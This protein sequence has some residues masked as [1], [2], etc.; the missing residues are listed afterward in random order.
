M[1]SSRRQ[2]KLSLCRFSWMCQTNMAM[3]RNGATAPVLRQNEVSWAPPAIIFYEYSQAA[4]T[5]TQRNRQ[6]WA[7]RHNSFCLIN[8]LSLPTLLC[9]FNLKS[10]SPATL[11]CW[12][13]EGIP[14]IPVQGIPGVI[15]K[16]NLCISHHIAAVTASP[17]HLEAAQHPA[18]LW[19]GRRSRA[20]HTPGTELPPGGS[21]RGAGWQQPGCPRGWKGPGGPGEAASGSREPWW[22]GEAWGE[23]EEETQEGL[24]GKNKL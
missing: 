16:D 12:Y 5:A 8:P 10:F 3:K 23:E 19:A 6:V 21:R 20:P 13:A 9:L 15:V 14:G 7:F 24:G 18:G 11:R 2:K 1:G 17:T 4:V 22:A